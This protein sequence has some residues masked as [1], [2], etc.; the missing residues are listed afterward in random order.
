[1]ECKDTIWR[2][3]VKT[4][5]FKLIT[6]SVTACFTGLGKAV[7]IHLILTAV[8]LIYERI[9]NRIKWGRTNQQKANL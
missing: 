6:T 9:W 3:V 7:A 5:F 4:L 2:S 8:Y 1:M